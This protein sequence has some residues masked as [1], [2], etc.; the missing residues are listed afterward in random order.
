MA[1]ADCGSAFPAE[2]FEV[3]AS[4]IVPQAN[5]WAYSPH[6]DGQR[7]LVNALAETGEP[8]VNVNHQLA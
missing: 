1:V 6:P 4:L 7:F 3:G 8:T 2:L 5:I